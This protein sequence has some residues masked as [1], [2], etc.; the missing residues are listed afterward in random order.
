MEAGERMEMGCVGG[1]AAAPSSSSIFALMLA[2]RSSLASC[3]LFSSVNVLHVNTSWIKT[4][5]EYAPE[6]SFT[7]PLTR[8]NPLLLPSCSFVIPFAGLLKGSGGEKLLTE[9]PLC[10]APSTHAIPKGAAEFD[11]RRLS[12]LLLLHRPAPRSVKICVGQK[13][14]LIVGA[15]PVLPPSVSFFW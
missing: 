3:S 2:R 10:S 11:L 12:L 7:N 4:E 8:S 9:L 14:F 5:V 1:E 15:T 6:T 13:K